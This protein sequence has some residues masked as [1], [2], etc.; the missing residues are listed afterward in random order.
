MYREHQM[1]GFLS[2]GTISLLSQ[3]SASPPSVDL[4]TLLLVSPPRFK[5]FS[6]LPNR[7]PKR[8]KVLKSTAWWY[9][10][11]SVK[12]MVLLT[13]WKVLETILSPVTLTLLIKILLI[14]PVLLSET[15]S[16]TLLLSRFSLIVLSWEM[17]LE[18][19]WEAWSKAGVSG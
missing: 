7:S 4:S 12:E 15:R 5:R 16:L 14:L 17:P 1:S 19:K 3:V 2:Y 10:K 11:Y 18:M 8:C 6:S 13:L 9:G